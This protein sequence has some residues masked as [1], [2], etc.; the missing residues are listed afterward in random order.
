MKPTAAVPA[1]PIKLH[2]FFL[3]GHSHRVELFLSL[4]KLPYERVDVDLAAGAHKRPAFL[5]MNPFGQ[6]PVMQDGEFTLADSNAILVYLA[7]QYD[8]GRWL[9]RDPVGAAAVQRWLSVAAGPVAFGPAT[10]RLATV[11]KAP[12]NAEEAIARAND[13]FVVMDA[14]LRTS[15]FLTGNTPTIADIANYT[16][17]AHAPEG[18]VSLDPYPHIRNW[19][20]RIE[21]LP[22]FVP[23]ATSRVGLAA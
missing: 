22:G 3:S 21:A 7:T 20:Q 13:L 6:V 4:L 11:F 17:I 19:L 12:V 2:R 18:N 5:A 14:E 1:Q 9:P 23:M 8:S 10:A 16:Y 15:S